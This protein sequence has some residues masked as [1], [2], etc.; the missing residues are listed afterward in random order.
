MMHV[1]W[2][3]PMAWNLGRLPTWFTDMK[4][5]FSSL[6]QWLTMEWREEGELWGSTGQGNLDQLKHVKLLHSQQIMDLA[7]TMLQESRLQICKLTLAGKTQ[8]QCKL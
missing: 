3:C 7:K 2:E 6:F 1:F 8:G 4:I 5:Y